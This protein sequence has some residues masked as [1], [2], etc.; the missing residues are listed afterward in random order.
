M[1]GTLHFDLDTFLRAGMT[2]WEIHDSDVTGVIRK[3]QRLK[4]W[5]TSRNCY[6]MR[7]FP[8]LLLVMAVPRYLNADTA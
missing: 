2:R 5:M 8:N 7:R 6:A 4:S 3:G 1:T